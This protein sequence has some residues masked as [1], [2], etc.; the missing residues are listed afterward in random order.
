V[1][2]L[3]ESFDSASQSSVP[4]FANQYGRGIIANGEFQLVDT[5]DDGIL[6]WYSWRPG[7]TNVSVSLRAFAADKQITIA[8][9]DDDRYTVRASVN[10]SLQQF[11]TSI[12]DKTTSTFSTYSDWTHS[13]AISTTEKSTLEMICRSDLLE[14][15]I[16]GRLVAS[17]TIAGTAGAEVWIGADGGM[18][19]NVFIDDI[20]I[21]I[22]N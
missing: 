14:F 2:F 18:G 7:A 12:Y 8:C 4:E 20:V 10:T 15:V 11:K 1:V 22:L 5:S 13:D 3:R 6:A 19:S 17:H 9:R 21:K 16:N